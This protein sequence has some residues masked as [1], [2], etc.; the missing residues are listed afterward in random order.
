M[1]RAAADEMTEAAEHYEDRRSG[2]GVRFLGCVAHTAARIDQF[3][4]I[5]APWR[6]GHEEVRRFAVRG[7][8]YFLIYITEPVVTIVAVAHAKRRP[9]YWM[10]RLRH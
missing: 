5:G 6:A 2:L 4:G 3:P 8:P 10:D 1:L 7:F 9:G